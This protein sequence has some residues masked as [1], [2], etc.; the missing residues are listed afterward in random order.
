MTMNNHTETARSQLFRSEDG[1]VS[2]I[3]LVI[4]LGMAVLIGFVGNM[5]SETIERQKLQNA[6]DATAYSQAVWL[7]RGMN[8][9]CTL[10]HIMG[11]LTSIVVIIEALGGPEAEGDDFHSWQLQDEKEVNEEIITFSASAP[12]LYDVSDWERVFDFVDLLVF[13]HQ[14]HKCGAAIYDSEVNLKVHGVACLLGK[15]VGNA[16]YIAAKIFTPAAAILMP[17]GRGI[18]EAMKVYMKWIT[19]EMNMIRG[20]ENV[21]P[22]IASMKA[23]LR[24]A[25]YALSLLTNS[26]PG[27]FHNLDDRN[28]I[29]SKNAEYFRDYYSR[30]YYPLESVFYAT[31]GLPV[32][33]E[34][35]EKKEIKGVLYDAH[36]WKGDSLFGGFLEFVGK[37]VRSAIS[38]INTFDDWLP[39]FGSAKRRINR[40]RDRFNQVFGD[41]QNLGWE[42]NPSKKKLE[43]VDV[44]YE[45]HTQWVRA[46]Y[47]YVDMYRTPLRNVFAVLVLSNF[48]TYFTAW[49]NRYTLNESYSLHANGARMSVM[50]ETKYHEIVKGNEPWT[51][52]A[53][54]ADNYF[55]VIVAAE[56]K[57][58]P[59]VFSPHYFK[60]ASQNGAVAI[61]QAMIYNLNG[62]GDSSNFA[63]PGDTSSKIQPNTG[64]DTLQWNP[65]MWDSELTIEDGEKNVNIKAKEW[66]HGPEGGDISG[67]AKSIGNLLSGGGNFPPSFES[68][69]LETAFTLD[70]PACASVRLNWQ[71]KLRPLTQASVRRLLDDRRVNGN[72]E[73]HCSP[74]QSGDGTL[75][76]TH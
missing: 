42:C 16:C 29:L 44:E 55:S 21:V 74:I 27:Q 52:D 37:Q 30:Q 8:T 49:T 13:S 50:P 63:K 31:H 59:S 65:A 12:N 75:F 45:Q 22:N 17:I 5:A 10:N 3:S 43:D 2:F 67:I 61:S 23:P 57:Q 20:I 69:F 25:I 71:S 68:D 33:P 41:K 66:K 36:P 48:K 64:W 15:N 76:M 39:G 51:K 1:S 62:R 60:K 70:A 19:W 24:K 72:V 7:A 73:S 18:H 11:E 26:I 47:P 6:A 46:T 56:G 40:A 58:Q 35:W 14:K 54:R 38:A 34:P 4:V 28:C 53:N 32:I 9:V